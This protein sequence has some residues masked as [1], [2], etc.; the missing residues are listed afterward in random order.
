MGSK[1]PTQGPHRESAIMAVKITPVR[2]GEKFGVRFGER[3]T[4]KGGQKSIQKSI[5][6]TNLETKLKTNLKILDLIKRIGP[7]RGGHWEV[8]TQ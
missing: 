6:K 1:W 8:V 5:Q 3:V 2:F 7:D 4:E